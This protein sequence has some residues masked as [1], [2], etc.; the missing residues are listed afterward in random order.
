M[1]QA[2]SKEELGLSV[3]LQG[4]MSPKTNLRGF[5]PFFSC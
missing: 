4:L 2:R 5:D 3:M 1:K